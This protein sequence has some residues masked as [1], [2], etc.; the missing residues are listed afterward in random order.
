MAGDFREARW[1]W[2]TFH[3]AMEH[4]RLRVGELV[5]LCCGNCTGEYF[6]QEGKGE[7]SLPAANLLVASG[8][9]CVLYVLYMYTTPH[10]VAFVTYYRGHKVKFQDR[11]FPRGHSTPLFG[12]GE[13]R[14]NALILKC[15]ANTYH[16]SKLLAQPCCG[17]LT[18]LLT[19]NAFWDRREQ[20]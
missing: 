12:V 3:L 19:K 20:R 4:A 6:V 18:R 7:P 1:R 9:D 8:T 15:V 5:V 11:L 10:Q 13:E 16:P 17:F 2:G 14:D